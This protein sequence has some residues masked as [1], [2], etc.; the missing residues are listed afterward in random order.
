[1]ANDSEYRLV[2]TVVTADEVRGDRIARALRPSWCG[3]TC[4]S[5]I[6]RL[7]GPFGFAALKEIEQVLT[8][9]RTNCPTIGKR[10]DF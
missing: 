6:G 5:S 2:A 4:R 10:E 9:R 3:S 1:M 7:L 8:H